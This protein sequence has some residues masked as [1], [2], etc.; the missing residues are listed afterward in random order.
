[1]VETSFG[2]PWSLDKLDMLRR[3]LDAYTTALKNQ[4]FRL[5]YIDAFAGEGSFRLN[6]D[7][8]QDDYSDF[9]AMHNGSAKVALSIQD[10]SFDKFVFSETDPQRYQVLMELRREFPD[11]DVT[12]HNEDANVM[13][14]QFCESLHSLDRAVVFLD[15]FA[16]SVSWST[17]AAIARTEKIDCW[18]LFPVGAIARMMPTDDQPRKSWAVQLD[19]IFGSREHW[20][21]LYRPSAQLS[22]FE[23][24]PGYER[25]GGS[26]PIADRYRERLES[27]FH[28][29]APTR[30]ILKNSR[31][32]PMFELFFAASNPTGASSAVRIADHIL[33]H[34]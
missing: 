15:P 3:Y 9:R 13:L 2:G 26:G 32:A 28:T 22:F 30:R 11:Q 21:G 20:T 6:S 25:P 19:R 16:T 12:V 29:V 31:N 24:N 27:A 18:I 17:V 23:S 33:R 8:Y 7:F 34:W 14:P 10:K 4:P 1:M 5:I